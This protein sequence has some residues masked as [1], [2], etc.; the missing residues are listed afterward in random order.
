[1]TRYA[2]VLLVGA[3][4]AEREEKGALNGKKCGLR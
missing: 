2:R 4:A 1:M 3:T